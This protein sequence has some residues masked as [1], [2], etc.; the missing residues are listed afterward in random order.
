MM[1]KMKHYTFRLKLPFLL[2]TITLLSLFITLGCWQLQ[3]AEQKRL[4]QQAYETRRHAAVITLDD[5][6]NSAQDQRYFPIKI[7]GHFDNAHTVLLDNRIHQH[8]VGYEVLTPLITQQGKAV[9]VNRGWIP[10]YKNRHQIPKIPPALGQQSLMG[11]VY[12]PQRSFRLN[13]K[14]DDA[15]HWPLRIQQIDLDQLAQLTG[16]TLYPVVV[17][18][19]AHQP[20]GFIRSWQPS[21]Q[22]TPQMHQGYALQWFTLALATLIIYLLLSFH[23]KSS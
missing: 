14:L 5:I 18:L 12:P 10:A 6:K 22:M 4:L 2:L 16:H 19:A 11:F 8:Q 3:R 13:Q 17:L 1:T 23:R 21:T 15:N 7:Q 20:H 9:F